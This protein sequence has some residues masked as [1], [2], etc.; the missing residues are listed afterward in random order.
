M[1]S[2]VIM[3]WSFPLL[4]WVEFQ[5]LES[6][7]ISDKKLWHVWVTSRQCS[8]RWM[9]QNKTDFLRFLWWPEG[10]LN[11]ELEVCRMTVHMFGA[12]S[13]PGCASYA[14]RKTADDNSS[15]FS[16]ETVQLVKQNVYVDDCLR[17]PQ[18]SNWAKQRVK[19]LGALC[20]RGGFVSEKWISNSRSVPQSIRKDLKDRHKLPI[21]K[22]LGLLWCVESDSFKFKMEVKQ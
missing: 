1:E 14:L 5:C 11:K 9:W 17:S 3:K 2:A 20:K 21:E 19:E 15:D 12:V 18:R 10:D 7:L 8:I 4:W 16:A 6:S 22:A 13:S